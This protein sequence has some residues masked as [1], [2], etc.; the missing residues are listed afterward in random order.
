M[1]T[2][3]NQSY[4]SRFDAQNL[5]LD[6]IRSLRQPIERIQQ[7]DPKLADQLRRAASAVPLNIA[8]G[9]RR[10]GKDKRYHWRVAAGSADEARYCLRVA[11]AW[12]YLAEEESDD[13]LGL[14]DRLGAILYRLTH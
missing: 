4:S 12:G 14:L 1:N 9:N 2:K 6:M 8:E 3:P 7:H 10:A 5:A 13:A 11:E